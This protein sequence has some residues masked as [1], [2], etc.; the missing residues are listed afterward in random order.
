MYGI[1]DTY[2]ISRS[3]KYYNQE[4]EI[5][6]KKY[7]AIVIGAGHN[8]LIS[9]LRLVDKGWK[10]LVVEKANQPGG[11]A[12]SGE[13]TE[14]GFIHDLYAMNIGLFLGSEFFQKYGKEMQRHGFE[15]VVNDQPYASVFPDGDG[16]GAFQDTNQMFQSI[17]EHSENDAQA[18]RE[19]VDYFD[20]TAPYFMP[21]M[22]MELPSGKAGR[23]VFNIFR[24]LKTNG[25]L[26]LGSHILKTPREFVNYWFE[27]D[28]TKALVVPWG[29][30]LDMAPDVSNGAVF[31]FLESVLN[32][33]NGMVFSKGGIQVMIDSIV[34]MIES[35]GGDVVT[36][37]TVDKIQVKKGKA[38]GVVL[39]DG[40]EIRAKKA[41]IGNVT[42]TQLANRL[43]DSEHLPETYLR[44]AEHYQYGPGTMMIHLSLDAPLDWDAGD[45]YQ[46]FAYIHIG[47]YVEDIARS[48]TQALNGELPDSPLLVVGQPDT[49]D[50]TR[51]PKGKSTLW[52][53]VR[54]LPSVP[55]GDALSEI[56]PAGWD[57][58]KEEYADRIID[59]L[60]HYAPNVKDVLRK[61]TVFSPADLENDNPNL[62]GGDSVSGSHHLFQNYLLR[63]MPGYSRYNTPIKLLH[64][65]GA[66]TWPGGG[67]NATSGWLLA[68]K[69]LK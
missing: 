20:E 37:A 69:L 8:G 7:D 53:Q 68:D 49:I 64:A 38:R 42:P 50:D 51:S 14:D 34:K 46:Q 24:K 27:N 26:E 52:I 59:K 65:V 60:A 57:V 44:G 31:P 10:V 32:H 56:E 17:K 33:R 12:K 13:I 43:V 4:G 19:M 67:L 30:H 39:E 47:P 18:W 55:K 1:H 11:A 22:Q 9:A 5:L 40:R 61:R 29:F 35:R 28:K 2:V 45:E 3:R 63:P 21:M 15:P 23:K 6:K 25:A 16:I 58:I 66:S 36:G 62:V 48:Y 54:A 41:V